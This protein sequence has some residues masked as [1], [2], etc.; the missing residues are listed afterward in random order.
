MTTRI[1]NRTL[2][3]R[4]LADSTL[5]V[6]AWIGA[7]RL[8][9]ASPVAGGHVP[10]IIALAPV[11]VPVQVGIWG[12]FGVYRGLWRRTGGFELWRLALACFVAMLLACAGAFLFG[13]DL[14]GALL[15]LDAILGFLLATTLRVGI[16]T[17]CEARTSPEG[18][19]ACRL[20]EKKIRT[21]PLCG[22]ESIIDHDSPS[23]L[24][25]GG[26]PPLH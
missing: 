10:R 1:K 23:E 7:C 18:H 6:A 4:V 12:L 25:A 16:R 21:C 9:L 13:L 2:Y 26:F 17:V 14:P 3:L 20:W 15:I 11:I 22:R 8:R 19:G 5:L 24:A